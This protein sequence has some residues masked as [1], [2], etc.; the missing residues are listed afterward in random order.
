MCKKKVFN[1]KLKK[2]FQPFQSKPFKHHNHQKYIVI[3]IIILIGIIGSII[4]IIT[5]ILFIRKAVCCL[6]PQ[7]SSGTLRTQMCRS[8]GEELVSS[9]LFYHILSVINFY[10]FLPLFTRFIIIAF[11]FASSSSTLH[12]CPWVGDLVWN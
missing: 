3:L 6:M 4:L 5:I 9:V 7:A 12:P 2:L 10:R 11:S 1:I 8:L